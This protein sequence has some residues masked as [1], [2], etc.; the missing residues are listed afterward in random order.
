MKVERKRKSTT[1]IPISS[2][3]K[4][5]DNQTDKTPL[6][7]QKS[8]HDEKKIVDNTVCEDTITETTTTTTTIN[9]EISREQFVIKSVFRQRYLL[10]LI[11]E[12][13]KELSNIRGLAPVTFITKI[14]IPHNI[15]AIALPSEYRLT[16]ITKV[17]N[18]VNPLYD[19]PANSM[20]YMEIDNISW[21]C[22]NKYT[23]LLRY[24]LE[25]NE[26]L[27]L[28]DVRSIYKTMVTD[29]QLFK[30]LYERYPK[31][32]TNLIPNLI[33][34]DI[35]RDMLEFI[36]NDL[37]PTPDNIIQILLNFI[38]ANNL[39]LVELML[40]FRALTALPNQ[41]FALVQSSIKSGL[42]MVKL[43]TPR[44]RSCYIVHSDNKEIFINLLET[45]DLELIEYY[46]SNFGLVIDRNVFEDY[47]FNANVTIKETSNPETIERNEQTIA[48]VVEI[49]NSKT[50]SVDIN[51][52]LEELERSKYGNGGV[53]ITESDVINMREYMI[54]YYP[55]VLLNQEPFLPE[56]DQQL[57]IVEYLHGEL[58]DSSIRQASNIMTSLFYAISNGLKQITYY[59]INNLDLTKNITFF[60]FE[61]AKNKSINAAIQTKQFDIVDLIFSKWRTILKEQELLNFIRSSDSF[62]ALQLLIKHFPSV[63]LNSKFHCTKVGY[64]LDNLQAE[65]F[66]IECDNIDKNLDFTRCGQVGL[67]TIITAY[68][69]YKKDRFNTKNLEAALY[70]AAHYNHLA[71]LQEVHKLLPDYRFKMTSLI[72]GSQSDIEHTIYRDQSEIRRFRDGKVGKDGEISLVKLYLELNKD[73]YD[74]DKI[75][76]SCLGAMEG[77]NITFLKEIKKFLP[78]FVFEIYK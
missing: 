52:R 35:T 56:S 45:Q 63:T 37:A 40:T 42:A 51:E 26:P 3:V 65:E 58:Q 74:A 39:E 15:T 73:D 8:N 21:M 68:L 49:L 17:P 76:S 5:D 55:F 9:N 4:D 59:I 47:L 19:L 29:K 70:G 22:R 72:R 16:G 24:K 44:F 38:R 62:A 36:M 1:N 41:E 25:R 32:F 31:H 7:K 69:N 34:K 78:D 48:K 61:T 30:Q 53:P 71:F 14:L 11:M 77:S 43:L 57:P 66:E 46:K 50:S 33:G 2:L 28:T 23:A 75:A 64:M 54:R 6:K 18:R 67:T 60:R 12:K 10:R 27:R 13:V 20:R